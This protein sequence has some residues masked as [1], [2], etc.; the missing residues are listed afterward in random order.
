M[1][2]EYTH[3]D[4]YIYIYIYMHIIKLKFLSNVLIFQENFNF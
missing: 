1:I 3:T 4:I 2:Q